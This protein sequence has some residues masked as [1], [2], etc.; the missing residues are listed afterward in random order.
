ME[1]SLLLTAFMNGFLGSVHCL[2]MCGPIAWLIQSKSES[3]FWSNFLY[4][5]GRT[6]SYSLVGGILGF[7]GWGLNEFFLADFAFWLGIFLLLFIS[8]G[9][10][11]P[12]FFNSHL[13]SPNSKYVAIF[14]KKISKIENVNFLSFSFG[15]L[16]GLL[17]CGLL[18]P[19]YGLALLSGS[20]LFGSL[21]M[22]VFSL[23]TY[24]MMF[25]VNFF[26]QKLKAIFSQSKYR[27][28]LGAILLLF[29]LY[30]IYYRF[31]LTDEESC[32]TPNT[33]ILNQ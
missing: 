15:I 33:E 2:G 27:Y 12:N 24:P 30:S 14:M 6:L 17:P 9:Y 22:F 26:S 13:F 18:Y 21:T 31:N 20:F 32:H 23:G 10:L 28:A 16:S 4:N 11:F 29:A 19:A 25:G 1:V 5:F 8:L 7:F 3:S